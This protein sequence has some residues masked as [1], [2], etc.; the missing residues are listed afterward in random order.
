MA[1]FSIRVHNLKAT[2]LSLKKDGNNTN[3]DPYIKLFFDQLKKLKTEIIHKSNNPGMELE[4]LH[5][6]LECYD[7]CIVGS[8][9]LVGSCSVDFKTMAYGPVHHRMVLRNRGVPNGT[10]EFDIEM[11]NLNET[12]LTFKSIRASFYPGTQFNYNA[13]PSSEKYLDYYIQP[14]QKPE[15]KVGKS[16]KS[17]KSNN[18]FWED[19][20]QVLVETSLKDLLLNPI[21]FKVRQYKA[22]NDNDAILGESVI[23]LSNLIVDVSQVTDNHSVSF[24]EPILHQQMVVGVLEGD[25][26][27]NNVSFISQMPEGVHTDV[28]IQGGRPLLNG[29]TIPTGSVQHTPAPTTSTTSALVNHAIPTTTSSP[30]PVASS[31]SSSSRLSLPPGWEARSDP[32][33]KVYYV[34]HNTKTSHW[35]LPSPIQAAAAVAPPPQPTIPP[36][37]PASVP[38]QPIQIQATAPATVFTNNSFSSNPSPPNKSSSVPSFPQ[39]Q[40][41]LPPQ[42]TPT[43]PPQVLKPVVP[44]VQPQMYPQAQ[45]QQPIYG[46][47]GQPPQVYPQQQQV[48]PGVVYAQPGYPGYVQ[49]PGYPYVQAQ[50]P[51]QYRMS[52]PSSSSS[53]H[54][55]HHCH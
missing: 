11:S 32:N 17:K 41:I 49:Q 14:Y 24:V 47:Y 25:L 8:D 1:I 12:L 52:F 23:Q 34:D 3:I 37:Q 13:D 35:D 30:A 40:P 28:G 33:G 27:F 5:F 38:T 39:A 20:D 19:I 21:I 10:I 36:Q 55:H 26:Y 51:A 53:C 44:Q 7:S 43:P 6:S 50:Y 54:G 9:N 46:I 2:D 18:L 16:Y 48:Y 15:T 31:P 29:Q 4:K 45:P 42:S 22:Y